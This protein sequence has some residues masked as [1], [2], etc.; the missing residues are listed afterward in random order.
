MH[1]CM[2]RMQR[3]YMQLPL[4]SMKVNTRCDAAA[5]IKSRIGARDDW[6]S[7]RFHDK[8]R[9]V[10]VGTPNLSVFAGRFEMGRLTT[11]K[12]VNLKPTRLPFIFAS[13]RAMSQSCFFGRIGRLHMVRRILPAKRW[14]IG[15]PALCRHPMPRS[16]VDIRRWDSTK[17]SLLSC[18]ARLAGV[19]H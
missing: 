17:Q 12:G 16:D 2:L 9:F 1:A 8:S 10:A 7:K 5:Q 4:P 6:L 19:L 18:F 3:R 11:R 13:S 15:F 14:M